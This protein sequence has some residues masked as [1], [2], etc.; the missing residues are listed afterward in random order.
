MAAPATVPAPPPELESK[1]LSWP[2]RARATVVDSPA[3][4]ERAGELLRDVKAL[5]L[6]IAE[7]HAPVIEAAH[8]AHKAALD[9]KKKLDE[10]LD[11]AEREIK[12]R[13]GDYHAEQERIRRE[14]QRRLEAEARARE[15]ERRLEEAAALEAEGRQE[16]AEQVLEEEP[17]M[18]EAPIAAPPTPKVAGVSMR[19]KWTA[20]VVDKAAFVRAC[21]D[22]PA[23]MP[24]V[25]ANVP[26]LN[27]QAASL[28]G[29]LR[30]PGVRV[31]REQ[32]V[33]ARGR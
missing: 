3:T 5:R 13:M 25:L 21:A 4:F 19:E 15:E 28:K 14:E 18:I 23:W 10:P 7:H 30:I 33:A 8:R 11:E 31:R 9:A 22:N 17:A 24:L 27:Q 16:E 1:A 29:E 26:A 6:E 12:R 2:Q 20:E 32:I